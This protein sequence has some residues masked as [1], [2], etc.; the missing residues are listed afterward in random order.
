VSELI[1]KIGRFL[2]R[3]APGRS[4][5]LA[6]LYEALPS[7][8]KVAI[9]KA[10]RRME[11]EELVEAPFERD[12]IRLSL[13]GRDAWNDGSI[14]ELTLGM[15]YVG[16]R[17][18]PATVHII[19][20]GV[21]G[22]FGGSGFFSAEYP[23]WIVTGAHVLL[24]RKILR[25]ENQQREIV[26]MPP[27]GICLPKDGIDLALV[28]CDCPPGINPIRIE[29]RR[30]K[31]EPMD[32]L[33]VLGYPPYP[34]LLTALDHVSAELRSVTTD[35]RGEFEHLV[36]SSVTRPGSSGG[37]VLSK[38]GRAIGVVEQDNEGQHLDGRVV[39]AFTATPALYLAKLCNPPG[40]RWVRCDKEKVVE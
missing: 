28:K 34:N 20:T 24:E 6:R 14:V 40:P 3:E 7:S 30:S 35:F 2:Y 36:M 29:W 23:G 33:L 31:I 22:E 1:S 26:A 10:L 17:Y 5:Q 9:G 18:G 11:D 13:V 37:P 4:V 19:V 25:I 12:A 27:F 16:R 39:H 15:E 32:R 8:D 38:R 21:S